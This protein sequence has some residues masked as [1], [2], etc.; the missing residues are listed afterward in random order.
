MHLSGDNTQVISHT[1]YCTW[2]L[3]SVRANP[4]IPLAPGVLLAIS[5]VGFELGF[6]LIAAYEAIRAL[7]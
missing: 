5:A 2:H 7:G 3:R 1:K 6:G 4:L